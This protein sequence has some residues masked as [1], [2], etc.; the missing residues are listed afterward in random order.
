MAKT[1]RFGEVAFFSSKQPIWTLES[2]QELYS[3]QQR[4]AAILTVMRGRS[5]TNV[6]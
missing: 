5:S 3:Q 6:G 4:E 2:T 1:E